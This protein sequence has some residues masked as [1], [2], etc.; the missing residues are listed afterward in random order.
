MLSTLSTRRLLSAL[1][2]PI[3]YTQLTLGRVGPAAQDARDAG[4]AVTASANGR[5]ARFIA[6]QGAL[7]VRL[8]VYTESGEPVTADIAFQDNRREVNCT[9]GGDSY[10]LTL[11]GSGSVNEN[12]VFNITAVKIFSQPAGVDL[13]C[14]ANTG[15]IDRSHVFAYTRR[16][17]ATTV[18]NV[19]VQ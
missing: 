19:V 16:L 4:P 17:T 2:S 7:R 9:L 1:A 18:G 6:P 5:G 10:V 8:E 11:G 12:T 14:K 15:G 3:L 13:L